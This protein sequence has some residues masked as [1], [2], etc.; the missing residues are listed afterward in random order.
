MM[1]M[2]NVG[3]KKEFHILLLSPRYEPDAYLHPTV[4]GLASNN[5]WNRTLLMISR[6]TDARTHPNCCGDGGGG[7]NG[8]DRNAFGTR[9]KE[10]EWSTSSFVCVHS[11]HCTR[12]D[13]NQDQGVDDGGERKYC[14][15]LFNDERKQ[16]EMMGYQ[17]VLC[18]H[19]MA[20]HNIVLGDA[21][22]FNFALF[23]FFFTGEA[24]Y[25]WFDRSVV[26]ESL[27]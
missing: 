18:Q 8:T 25:I 11:A 3:Y 5:K 15:L 21:T 17:K 22:R 7:K 1:M 20:T 23:Y 13:D 6:R 4:C 27:R 12:I 19:Q 2:L 14:W 10:I 9:E 16:N 24:R 26:P